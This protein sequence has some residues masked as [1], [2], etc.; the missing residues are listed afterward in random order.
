V[1]SIQD[2]AHPEALTIGSNA[3]TRILVTGATGKIGH[4]VVDELLARGYQVRALTSKRIAKVSASDRLE[5]CQLD[6]QES[7]DFD[8]LVR[9]CAAVIHLGAEISVIE[10][11]QRSNVEATHA[12]AEAS[13]RAGVKFFC[14]TSSVAVYGSSRRRR[15][16]EDSPVLT[17]DRDV[18]SEYW[19]H[20][21]LRCYGRT[22]LQGELAIGTMAH[23][24][25]YVILRPST[26]VD[27]QDLFNLAF[28]SKISKSA[29]SSRHAHHI[30]V[31]D[32]VDAILWFMERGLTRDQPSP[33]VSKFNLSEDDFPINTWGQIF[34][35]AYK[36]TGDPRW[37]VVLT[38]PQS[39]QLLLMVIR[40]RM[41]LLRYPYGLMLFSNDK[42][43]TAGYTI[44]FG[45]S[46]ALDLFFR[47]LAPA[48]AS[49]MQDT[50]SIRSAQDAPAKHSD[51]IS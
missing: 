11:M 45:M 43:R 39:F 44:R 13:E 2:S 35:T 15:V 9:E 28:R 10:R 25:E 33:G 41:L 49:A 48:G 34:R 5:W 20:E 21:G 8:P 31:Y 7:L 24:V 36:I 17:T 14:Y 19:A 3:R 18:R 50:R 40:F 47:E 22:K 32:V 42:L 37:R 6:F 4:H 16:L 51:P 46:H 27:V 29:T 1:A 30:Y 23:N 12:L 38:V 26:V